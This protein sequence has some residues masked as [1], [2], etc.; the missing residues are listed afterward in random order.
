MREDDERKTLKLLFVS[1]VVS[2]ITKNR[3]S[4]ETDDRFLMPLVDFSIFSGRKSEQKNEYISIVHGKFVV[5]DEIALML[6]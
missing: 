3:T 4:K 1:E 5:R 2:I 6:Y